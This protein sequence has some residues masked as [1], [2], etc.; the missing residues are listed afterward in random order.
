M[1]KL[2]DTALLAFTK[3]RARKT[4]TIITVL[5]ASLL[6]GVLIATSLVMMGAFRSVESFRKDGLTSRYIVGVTPAPSP[7]DTLVKLR[8]NPQLIAEAKKRYEKLVEEKKAEAQRL[9]LTYTQTSDQPPYTQSSDGQNEVLALNDRNGIVFDLLQEHFSDKPVIDDAKL[10]EVAREYNAIN[11]FSSTY[12]TVLRGSTLD[13]LPDGKEVFYDQSDDTAI[14]ANYV[15]PLINKDMLVLAPTEIT[16]PFMLPNNAGWQSE[17]SNIPIILPQNAVER[18]L[19]KDAPTDKMGAEEKLAHLKKL[20]E[21]ATNLTFQACYRNNAS[22]A[23]IQQTLQQQKEMKANQGK[24]DYQKPSVIYELPDPAKCENPHVASD[25]RTDEAKKQDENQK[26]F[27]EKF[28]NATDPESYFVTFKVVGISPAEAAVMNPAQIQAQEQAGDIGDI[29]DNLLQTNGIGQVIPQSLYDELEK[30]AKEKYANLFTFTPTYFVGNEDDN[31]R[32]VEFANPQDAQ[33]FIDEQ[34]CTVQVE[35]TCQPTGRAYQLSLA[36][37]NSAALDDIRDK[38]QEWFRYAMLAVIVLAAMIMWITI[39]RAIADGRH[40][41]AVFRAIGFKRGD[42]AAVYILYTVMLS[43]LVAICAAAI[44]WIGAYIANQQWAPSLTAQAQY[45]FGG[46][47]MAKEVS[48]MGFD[49]Q[50][51]LLILVACFATGLLSMIVPLF[52][53]VRRSPIRDMREE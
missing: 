3:L 6:F 34:G 42:I 16:R 21:D 9:G 40:E 19:D 15:Q 1:I 35:G 23:L 22:T 52:G 17:S 47:D 33:K 49:Q 7:A 48:L 25:T 29:V 10:K 12:R 45:G 51:L 4:R 5:L 37:T 13:V 18:L 46:L 43:V 31:Q 36:F 14:N 2:S 53:N 32:Y 44:G 30:E 11:T 27:D 20:R 38:A 50:Q 24:D 28:S 8:R 26:L 39:G 41:T